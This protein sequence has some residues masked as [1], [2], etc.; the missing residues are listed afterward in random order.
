MERFFI[1]IRDGETLMEDEEGSVLPSLEAALKEAMQSAKEI[2]ADQILSG[3]VINARVFEITDE[4]GVI[5][6]T[7]LLRDAINLG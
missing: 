5:R 7:Y 4:S 3:A 6:A 2:L 1:N